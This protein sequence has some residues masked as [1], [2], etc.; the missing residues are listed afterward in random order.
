MY[1]CIYVF[2]FENGSIIFDRFLKC[3]FRLI[4]EVLSFGK[5][6]EEEG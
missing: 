5:N 4:L 3:G 2:E 6:A 1:L